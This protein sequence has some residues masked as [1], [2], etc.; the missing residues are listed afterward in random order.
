MMDYKGTKLR[1]SLFLLLLFLF[2][3]IFA[4]STP[5]WFPIKKGPSSRAKIAKD[6]EDKE[7]IIIDK[8]EYVKVYNP[9]ASAGSPKYLYIPVKEYLA[10]KG[11]Y[12]SF[13]SYRK[14]EP[15]KGPSPS[16]PAS[17]SPPGADQIL[18]S[19]PKPSSPG[20]KKKVVIAH[21]D[22]RMVQTEEIF[23]DW[24]AEK[25]VREVDRKAQRILLVDYRMVREFLESRGIALTDMQTP[26]A[27]RLLNEVFGIHAL[28]LGHLAGPYT[29]V[30]KGEKEPEGTA[31]ALIKIEIRLIDTLTGKTL[32]N[33]EASNPILA[34]KAQGS[35]S[36]E[37]AKVKAID[38][39]LAN[40]TG[41]LSRELD[42]LDWFA[43]V[44]KIEG[45]SV[46]LNAGRLTGIK[47][48]DVM[49][50]YQAGRPGERSEPKGKIRIVNCFGIDASMG[51]LIQG[52]T[53]EVDDILRLAGS[54]GPKS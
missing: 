52:R 25:L 23:G 28:V 15:K 24:I 5:S 19:T 26:G 44:A 32:K 6:L 37:R 31:S 46:F 13:S 34:A 53:P 42:N 33:L 30:T 7:V 48:G 14:E 2:L 35:F 4:C 41:P 45:D 21:F 36:E 12:K 3:F 43:R 38:V 11:T 1:L 16:P 22:D 50:V 8:E 18:V 27:L 51:S 49:E 29:F 47:E 54:Q 39:T 20:L 10:K 40:L 17:Q 9:G